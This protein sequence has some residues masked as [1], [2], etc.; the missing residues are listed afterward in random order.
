[1]DKSKLLAI[2]I[3]RAVAIFPNQIKAM[4]LKNAVVVDAENY[5]TNQLVDAVADGLISS[6]SFRNDFDLFIQQN[7]EIILK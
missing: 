6:E 2:V 3:G 7:K 5:D 1:M 4:L